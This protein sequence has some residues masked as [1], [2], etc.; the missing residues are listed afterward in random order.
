VRRFEKNGGFTLVELLITMAI[1]AILS[2]VAYPSYTQHIVKTKRSAAESF[3]VT[4]ANRQEQ[5]MLNARSYFQAATGVSTEWDAV[6]MTV[7][8]EVSD[9]YTVTVTANNASTPPAYTVT[10][11]P[12][13]SQLARD[14]KCASL[15]YNQAGTKARSGTAPSVSDCW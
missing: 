8:K 4:V 7:P 1:V 6:S 5:S 10:A 9:N 11:A 2:A 3:M 13:G 14:G 12:I 15:T